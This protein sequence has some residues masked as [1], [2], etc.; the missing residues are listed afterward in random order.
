MAIVFTPDGED[1]LLIG[2][3]S[4]GTG[5]IG[6]FPKYSISREN[7]YAYDGNYLNT[8]FTI[9]ISGTAV[10]RSSDTQD[11][12]VSGERQHRIQGE[13]SNVLKLARGSPRGILEIAPYGGLSNVI[14]FN[15]AALKSAD[16]SEQSDESAGIQNLPYSFVFEAY[17]DASTNAN[18]EPVSENN[19]VSYW[20]SDA[21]DSWEFQVADTFTYQNDSPTGVINKTYTITRNL[22][23]TG[24]YNPIDNESPILQAKKWVESKL[25]S[26]LPATINPDSMN[27]G[28]ETF[29]V[30]PPSNFADTS[31]HLSI[32]HVRSISSD[33]LSGSYSVTDIWTLYK[34]STATHDISV[35]VEGAVDRPSTSVSVSMSIQGI[36]T[37]VYSSVETNKYQN[38]LTSF[39]ILKT[40]AYN[41]A[42]AAYTDAGYAGNLRTIKMSES[43]GTNKNAGSI[44]YSA[45]FDDL[46]NIIEG[47]ANESIN[48]EDDNDDGLNQVIAKIDIIGKP[49]GP[50]IQ[51]MSTT[52]IKS[53]SVTID[54]VMDKDHRINKPS[55]AAMTL[56]NSYKPT[57]NAFRQSKRETW[58][59]KTGQYNLSI[60]WEY[61]TLTNVTLNIPPYEF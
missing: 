39:N 32:N 1:Q 17:E 27:L 31:S 58:N 50:V 33:V 12:T 14:R 45:T 60:N 29:N 38:A 24:I 25:I 46:V 41:I 15:D 34:G 4:T 7:N 47:A 18:S 44:T 57:T 55:A 11:I 23:A 36:D 37:S 61:S 6:P 9:N 21:K 10:I 2:G 30:N 5:L 8:K 19:P 53:R 49:D 40:Q 26:T 3:Q 59:P 13:V 54:V 56:V 43:T 48:I 35:S 16:V 51:D 42:N 28:I 52:T 22:S 20:I